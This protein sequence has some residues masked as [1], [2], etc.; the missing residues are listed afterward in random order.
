M[1][2]ST[3]EETR[4]IGHGPS[5]RGLRST[6]HGRKRLET[7]RRGPR[8]ATLWVLG[9]FTLAP[10]DRQKRPWACPREFHVG[11]YKCFRPSLVASNLTIHRASLWDLL[12]CSCG[13]MRDR[14]LACKC[15]RPGRPTPPRCPNRSTPAD[16]PRWRRW[17]ARRYNRWVLD[18]VR[19]F[20][21]GRVLEAGAGIGNLAELLLGQERL[22]LLDRDPAYVALL[23]ARFANHPNV[24]AGV[25]DLSAPVALDAWRHERIDTV[26]CSNVLEHIEHDTD[27]LC[28]FHEFLPPGGVCAVI[29]PAGPRLYGHLDREL[30]H[31]RRYSP[32]GLRRLLVDAGFEVAMLRRFNRLGALAWALSGRLLRRR[33]VTTWQMRWFDRLLPVVKGLEYMLPVAGMSLAA[34]G[35]RRAA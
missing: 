35:R 29:V 12:Q 21:G 33:R 1:K 17:P 10:L 4:R 28:R 2:R 32:I 34:V 8:P 30:G 11:C 13:S 18:Q 3:R 26:L 27:V 19:P 9:S 14:S 6:V 7:E 22:V 20:L 5:Q 24:R 16:A 31:V 25:A 23:E 15:H